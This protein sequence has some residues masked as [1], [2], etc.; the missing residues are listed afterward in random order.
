ME[1]FGMGQLHMASSLKAAFSEGM[2]ENYFIWTIF[3]FFF[4]VFLPFLGPLLGHMEVR[5][6]GVQ[7][8]L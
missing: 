2:E 8:E 6:L 1:I 7:S 3:N 5:R 4:F